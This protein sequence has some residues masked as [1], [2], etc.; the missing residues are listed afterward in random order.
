MGAVIKGYH[1]GPAVLESIAA[2]VDEEETAGAKGEDLGIIGFNNEGGL[3]V[4]L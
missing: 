1:V 2:R 4:V 3:L